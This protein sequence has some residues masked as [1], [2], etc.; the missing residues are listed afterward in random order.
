[1]NDPEKDIEDDLPDELD[2]DEED[3]WQIQ[4]DAFIDGL[5]EKFSP[6]IRKFLAKHYG[7]DF[8]DLP[9][10]T[11]REI[12]RIIREQ[13]HLF[14]SVFPDVLYR[15]RTITDLKEYDKALDNYV[16]DSKPVPWHTN[17]HWFDRDFTDEDMDQAESILD[18]LNP[19]EITEQ[20]KKA[21]K[22]IDLATQVQNDEQSFALFMRQ[23]YRIMNEDIR[24]YLGHFAAFDLSV[25][26]P[27]GFEALADTID[28]YITS[29][30]E[31]L[32]DVITPGE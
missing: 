1:M 31:E 30:L 6:G 24:Q 19:D 22:V 10:E 13:I 15:H 9:P 18:E 23:G 20:E 29:L 14:G 7:K 2:E 11:Y 16:R 17:E 27:E 8:Y 28:D 4:H 26:S 3:G 21:K 5:V 12:D 25:L 32:N